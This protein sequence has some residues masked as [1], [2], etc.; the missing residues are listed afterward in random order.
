MQTMMVK[1]GTRYRKATVAE[2][3][4][5]AGSYALQAFNQERPSLASPLN[6]VRHLRAMYQGLDH[7]IFSVLFLDRRNRL[8]EC[9][10]M[11]R[12]TIDGASVHPRE[13][14]KEVIWRGAAAVIFAHNHPS[15]IAEPSQ[16]DESITKLLR[17]AL[18]MIDVRVLDHIIIGG[19]H[20]CSFSERGLM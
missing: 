4:E 17:D 14:L 10:E 8:I 2:V 9:V 3:C 15:G 13:V 19:Q 6:A 5:V 16:A 1:S 11:F 12:G 7:E 18:A 20:Y